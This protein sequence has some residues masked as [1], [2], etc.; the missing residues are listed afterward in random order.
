MRFI[1]GFLRQTVDIRLVEDARA[2]SA[3]KITDKRA[4]Q[5]GTDQDEGEIL[6]QWEKQTSENGRNDEDK[7]VFNWWPLAEVNS[8]PTKYHDGQQHPE[9]ELR[10]RIGHC[11]RNNGTN[12]YKPQHHDKRQPFLG[13]C[14]M[15]GRL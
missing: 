7:R 12:W 9:G 2:V 3:P 10:K 6:R 5:A 15:H 8:K 13:F 4:G 14:L 1:A 11:T